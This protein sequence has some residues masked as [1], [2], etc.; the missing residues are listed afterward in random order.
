V[1]FFFVESSDFAPLVALSLH[2]GSYSHRD[3][4]KAVE[5]HK[6]ILVVEDDA[7]YQTLILEAFNSIG[8]QNPI[9]TVSSG[10]Q[11]IAYLIGEGKFADRGKYPY[12]TF[13]MT[14][15]KM[16]GGD[17]LS[18]LEHIK[19]NPDWD[20]IPK[21]VLSS[22]EDPD[23]IRKAYR[24]GAS[25][26]HLKPGSQA[27][28]CQFLKTLHEYWMTCKV[29]EVDVTGKQVQTDR[30]KMGERVQQPSGG[31]QNGIGR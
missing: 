28:L 21:V 10:S 19:N 4:G 20:I 22:S 5:Y 14:D 29:P 31:T 25:C 3:S 12:P 30:R 26:Y 15:M 9:Q 17:G 6:T 8:L 1:G 2:E 24:L 11:A 7:D 13:I 23:D 16:V 18:V 27:E